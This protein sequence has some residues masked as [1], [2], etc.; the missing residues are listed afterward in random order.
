MFQERENSQIARR[1]WTTSLLGGM[2]VAVGCG[3]PPVRERALGPRGAGI[4]GAQAVEV[5]NAETATPESPIVQVQHEEEI[6]PPT[7]LPP[8]V[9]PPAD[10]YPIDLVTALQL[11]GANNL[12][13]ALASA[14][15]REAQARLEGAQVQWLPSLNAG[16]GYNRHTGRVQDT[17]G[18]V[19]DR[20]RNALFVGGGP[21]LGPAPLTG[22]AGPP[23]RLFLGLPLADVFFAPLAERQQV[24]AASAA[25]A[26]TFNDTLLQVAQAYLDLVFAEFQIAITGEAVENTQ[27][28][29]RLVESR[30]RAGTAPPADGLR[31]GAELAERKRQQ[32]Q[33]EESVVIASAELSRLLRLDPAVVLVAAEGEPAPLRLVDVDT[34]LP[35]L[36]AQGIASRPELSEHRALVDAT[37]ARLCQEQRR[38]WFPTVQVGYGA[39]GFG[40]GEGTFFGRFG[41]RADFDALLVWELRNLGFGNRALQRQ[42]ASQHVQAHLEAEVFQDTIAAEIARAYYQVQ[43]RQCQIEAARKAVEAAA[44]TVP[45]NFTGIIGGDL[46]AIEGLQSVQTLATARSQYLAAVVDYNR[47]QFQLL[48]ALGL[49]PDAPPRNAHQTATS[50]PRETS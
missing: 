49:P 28:L 3:S 35:E 15:I 32:F 19:I 1:V 21:N 4:A 26:T 17:A 31:A 24:R 27:E 23:A 2:L 10:R 37:L 33:S 14:R 30:V 6:P 12:Q 7:L 22:P 11:A 45:L 34:P 36:L 16:V 48:R 42:R 44:E 39:G 50:S 38:P 18:L 40:G 43:Y 46:R 9:D 25:R 47:A 29:Q 13:I 20:D 41:E 8:R 5:H